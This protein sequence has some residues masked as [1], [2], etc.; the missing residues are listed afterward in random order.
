[1]PGRGADEV[2]HVAAG[3]PLLEEAQRALD[4]VAAQHL[5]AAFGVHE[6]SALG[7]EPTQ[8]GLVE[9]ELADAQ[10]PVEM[11]EQTGR[12]ARAQV[13][14]DP[15]G[16]R[17]PR[18]RQHDRHGQR[19]HDAA[20]E[21]LGVVARRSARRA[22]CRRRTR[23]R[24]RRACARS[25]ANAR[26][27]SAYGSVSR[28]KRNASGPASQ[29]S[30]AGSA[31]VASSEA[32]SHSSSARPPSRSSRWRP[33]PHG[34]RISRSSPWSTQRVTFFS[35]ARYEPPCGSSGLGRREP[36][37]ERLDRTVA[38][39]RPRRPEPDAGVDEPVARDLVDEPRI[40]VVD[41]R[42]AVAVEVVGD[43]RRRR[44]G[45][46]RQRLLDLGLERRA[47]ERE[48]LAADLGR[49][50]ED[51]PLGDRAP[52]E[53]ADVQDGPRA[54]GERLVGLPAGELVGGRGSGRGRCRR[55]RRARPRR[56]RS[57]RARTRRRRRRDARGARARPTIVGTIGAPPPP[58]PVP[59]PSDP[60]R[61]IAADLDRMRPFLVVLAVALVAAASAVAKP[62]VRPVEPFFA[63]T[64]RADSVVLRQRPGGSGAR[65][66][67]RA[68]GVRLARR[69]SA[70]PRTRGNWVGGHLHRAAERRPRLGAAEGAQPARSRLVDR[71]SPSRRAGSSLTRNGVVVR[72]VPVGIG[73]ADSPTPV[74][75]YVVTDHIDPA[76]YGTSA[77]GCCILALSGHQPHPPAGLEPEPRLA[78]RDPRRRTR[79]G[80]GRLRARRRRDAALPD[81]D[82]PARDARHGRARRRSSDDVDARQMDV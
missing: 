63:A 45:D 5:P 36:V 19:R 40:E 30:D 35:S 48:P 37:Q 25:G 34:A 11:R 69:R 23:S 39:E 55:G 18:R 31:T 79:R 7:R 54:V 22:A 80:L 28:R 51:E 47:P 16:A 26:G 71:R 10:L 67:A 52:R 20:Q 33:T 78:A 53:L 59:R 75:R 60:K 4:V 50:R 62:D 44:G 12:R 65:D 46:P 76:D 24:A 21:V 3:T 9:P 74:G 66:R 73:A 15:R 72:R 58:G 70:S 77:Y 29:R 13:R 41:G 1:M 27:R 17:R 8:L 42:D 6:R 38:P 57:R 43:H 32:C 49:L 64:P 68:D 81:A 56:S 61:G 14:A 2:D 82:D